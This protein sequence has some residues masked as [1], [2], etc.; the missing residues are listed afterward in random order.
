ME[1]DSLTRVSP[2][3]ALLLPVILVA[4]CATAPESLQP[5]P[6]VQ[7][8]VAD[9]QANPQAAAGATVVWGG[10]IAAI[11][12]HGDGTRLEVL[13]RPLDG[14]RRP[15]AD[16][17]SEGRFRVFFAGFLDPHVYAPLREITV[18]GRITGVAEGRIGEF[19]YRFPEV[20]AVSVHLWPR[21]EPTVIYRDPFWDPWWPH[22]RNPGHPWHRGA[23]W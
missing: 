9:A 10:T 11:S 15:V 6:E 13:A 3:P 18:R 21:P 17:R 22:Y 12:N 20:E 16:D 2:W 14:V 4:G 7:P 1:T 19:P 8:G 23:W 5:V